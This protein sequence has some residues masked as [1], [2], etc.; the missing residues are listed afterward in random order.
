MPRANTSATAIPSSAGSATI[1]PMQRSGPIVPSAAGSS[2]VLTLRG[3]K[4]GD[5]AHRAFEHHR[6]AVDV[7]RIDVEGREVDVGGMLAE[8]DGHPPANARALAARLWAT[9]QGARRAATRPRAVG[10]GRP[11]VSAASRTSSASAETDSGM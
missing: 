1:L 6:L 9:D 8:G 2:M 5:L 3:E 11:S 7:G 4:P 10:R